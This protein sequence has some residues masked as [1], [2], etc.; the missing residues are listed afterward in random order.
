M[1]FSF[2]PFLPTLSKNAHIDSWLEKKGRRGE[3]KNEKRGQEEIDNEN[4]CL[5]FFKRSHTKQI[6]NKKKKN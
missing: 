1:C 2:F 3:N 5:F 6:V 4:F